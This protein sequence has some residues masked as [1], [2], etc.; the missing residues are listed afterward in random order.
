MRLNPV[1]LLPLVCCAPLARGFE[2]R[3]IPTKAFFA[4]GGAGRGFSSG[5]GGSRFTAGAI[6]RGAVSSAAFAL[7]AGVGFGDGLGEGFGERASTAFVSIALRD[8]PLLDCSSTSWA[9]GFRDRDA[10]TALAERP[11]LTGSFSSS[12][13]C[14]RDRGAGGKGPPLPPRGPP[15]SWARE[16]N[17]GMGRG[18]LF[19]GVASFDSGDGSELFL[20][21]RSAD[22]VFPIED[23]CCCCC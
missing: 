3:P 20:G 14:L 10:S 8:R 9:I 19:T 7:G 5:V 16:V 15:P 23:S 11:L 18:F 4:G 2:G 6:V 1:L 17:F 13:L 21:G 12:R 22:E